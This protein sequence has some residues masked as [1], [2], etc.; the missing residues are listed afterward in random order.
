VIAI[1]IREPSLA[2][3]EAARRRATGRNARSAN[4]AIGEDRPRSATGI[5]RSEH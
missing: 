3:G 4:E 5:A 1:A 2:E